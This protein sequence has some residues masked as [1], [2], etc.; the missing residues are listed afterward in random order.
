MGLFQ[1]II[2]KTHLLLLQFRN[3]LYNVFAHH[4]HLLATALSQSAPK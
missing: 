3:L 2:A 1:D 4:T